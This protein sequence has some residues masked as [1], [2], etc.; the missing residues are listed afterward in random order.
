MFFFG[1][2]QGT[3]IRETPADLFAFVPTAAMLAGDF[4]TYASAECNSGTART[5]G[6]PFVGNR[7]DPS[8]MSPAAL[9]IARRLPATTD[10]CGRIGYSRSRPQDDTQYIGKMDVQ[11]GQN[12][13][14]FG[15]YIFTTNKQTPPLE[16]QPENLLVSSLGGRDNKSHSLTVGDTLVLS[17][18]MVNAFRV[19]YN[20]TD[21]HRTHQPL[22]FDTTD[23]GIKTYSYLEDYMLL[24]VNN[25]GF[26]LGGGTESEARFKTPSVNFTDDLTV[27]KGD[28]QYGL[29]PASRSGR[30]CRRPTCGRR[31][32][33]RSR[34]RTP[35]C[36]W[37]TSSAAG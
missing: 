2:F 18:S 30:R 21:I 27:I 17:N 11:L 14:M 19:A 26:Q 9:N 1:A 36:H 16:L 28:H 4:T 29:V 31:G 8:R 33:S 25:G 15:R 13:S 7:L 20:Y 32:N 34:A 35:A 12:H 37:P 23:L 10:P 22:G 24:G 5:L 3:R 6:A